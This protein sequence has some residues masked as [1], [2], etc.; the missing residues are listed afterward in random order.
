MENHE[1]YMPLLEGNSNNVGGQRL[2]YGAI[3]VVGGIVRDIADAIIPDELKPK[4]Q[5][6]QEH[7]PPVVIQEVKKIFIVRQELEA[8]KH[9]SADQPMP[10]EGAAPIA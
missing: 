3:E 9:T 1:A 4:D 8:I 10:T 6:M 5:S 7:M 2:A